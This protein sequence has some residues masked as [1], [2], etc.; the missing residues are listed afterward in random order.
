V[1]WF[2]FLDEAMQNVALSILPCILPA[3]RKCKKRCS[4]D[5]ALSSFIDVKPV[6]I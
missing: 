3:G 1:Y 2:H 6:S 4:I 5:N